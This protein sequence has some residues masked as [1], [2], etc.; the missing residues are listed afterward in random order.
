M[1]WALLTP[2]LL[3]QGDAV[4]TS[5]WDAS[6]WRGAGPSAFWGRASVSWRGPTWAPV[7]WLLCRCTPV[8]PQP[9]P[10]AGPSWELLPQ[11]LARAPHRPFWKLLGGLA[12]EASS[13]K[14]R[15]AEPGRQVRLGREGT[16]AREGAARGSPD[17]PRKSSHGF[18]SRTRDR[19]PGLCRELHPYFYL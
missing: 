14:P 18:L 12:G 16:G 13:P 1:A 8:S 9:A 10:T 15:A 11:D 17:A 2:S 3:P 7:L 19:P 6:S 4:N 5:P